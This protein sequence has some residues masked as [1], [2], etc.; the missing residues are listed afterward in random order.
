MI[1]QK[2]AAA[3]PGSTNPRSSNLCIKKPLR[4]WGRTPR[5][6]YSRSESQMVFDGLTDSQISCG[7]VGC[8]PRVALVSLRIAISTSINR[9]SKDRN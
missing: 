3:T 2:R 5:N 4:F 1:R 9:L 6:S 8:F 7:K